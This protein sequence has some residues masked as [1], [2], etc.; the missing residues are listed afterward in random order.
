MRRASWRSVADDVEAAE[1]H[2]LV[3]FG[4]GLALEGAEDALVVRPRHA[5]EVV[6]VEEVDELVVVDELLLALGQLLGDFLGERLLPRHELGVAAEE[7]V[8]AAARHVGGNRHGRLASRL[9]DDLRF[10][11]VILRVQ[12]DVLDAAQLQELRRAAPTF[13]SKRYRRARAGPFVCCSMMSVTIASY[14]SF[15]VR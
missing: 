14:F 10:L 9:G 5:V 8:G 4:V 6:E 11:R 7:D 15:S 12:D 1:I 13:R 3:V 2:D